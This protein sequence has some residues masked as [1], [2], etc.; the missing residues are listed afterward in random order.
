MIPMNSARRFVVASLVFTTLAVADRP[1][2]AQ[3]HD[4]LVNGALIGG[5]VG[6]GAGVAFAHAVRDS[7]LTLGQYAYGALIFGAIGAG[8][9]LGVDALFDRGSSSGTTPQRVVI[10]PAVWRGVKVVAVKLRW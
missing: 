5:A 3:G 2:A 8:I 9:G 1:V 10:T 4:S 6:A 7:D